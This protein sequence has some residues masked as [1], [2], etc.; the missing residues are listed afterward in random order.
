MG[1]SGA[2]RAGDH[3]LIEV[4]ETGKAELYNLK[5][6]IGETHNLAAKNPELVAKLKKML[7]SWRE[8]TGSKPATPNA[9]YQPSSD[10]RK[11]D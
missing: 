4:F 8:L 6:D 3:K 10:W 9:D 11:T 7:Q 1:P 5:D 2:I